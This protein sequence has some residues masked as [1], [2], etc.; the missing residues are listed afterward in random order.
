VK[1]SIN[2][3]SKLLEGFDSAQLPVKVIEPIG[4]LP[5]ASYF[6]VPTTALGLHHKQADNQ[7]P[8]PD[9]LL[10]GH[11]LTAKSS[12]AAKMYLTLIFRAQ[13][14]TP[15]GTANFGAFSI[16]RSHFR[17]S[18]KSR[19][20]AH[21]SLYR[22]S[23]AGSSSERMALN[24]MLGERSTSKSFL[25]KFQ[26]ALRTLKAHDFV[27]TEPDGYGRGS[28]K[29]LHDLPDWTLHL[30]ERDKPLVVQP[31]EYKARGMNHPNLVP[32]PVGLV[33]NGWLALLEPKELQTLF[34]V[35]YQRI[36]TPKNR[37]DETARMS[38]FLST[39]R[40]LQ[41]GLSEDT[42]RK[43]HRRLVELQILR[44]IDTK[45]YTEV[46]GFGIRHDVPHEFAILDERLDDVA[47]QPNQSDAD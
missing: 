14:E 39:E 47:P 46:R 37:D 4:S 26:T 33:R 20:G 21:L 13:L 16:Y 23:K 3:W 24:L 10:F 43:A 22:P 8:D 2:E 5:G 25:R 40:R 17:P 30:T 44:P 27:R 32:V 29:R 19:P 12:F 1:S 41:C 9:S 6:G 31:A 7:K 28:T 36:S 15:R 35:Y 18:S 42:Y 45:R 34:A 38:W 11:K